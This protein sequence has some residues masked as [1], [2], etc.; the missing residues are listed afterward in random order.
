MAELSDG[1][2][3]LPGGWGTLEEIAEVT[4]W[5]QLNI[6]MK[7]VG[8]LNHRNYWD[9]LL[10]WAEN[11]CAEGA[12]SC[13]SQA[14]LCAVSKTLSGE[15][16]RA[17]SAK[18]FMTRSSWQLLCCEDSVEELLE[19]LRSCRLPSVAEKIACSQER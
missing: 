18:G 1:F 11:A 13:L 17:K 7:P 10:K 5:T 6:H 2:V 14:F 16:V 15:N 4:T 9:F 3:A 8:L 19:V 12:R